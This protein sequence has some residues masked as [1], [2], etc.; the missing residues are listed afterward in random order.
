LMASFGPSIFSIVPRMRMVCGSCA[1]AIE[2]AKKKAK[3][4]AP[5]HPSCHKCHTILPHMYALQFT[6]TRLKH[7]VRCVVPAFAAIVMVPRQSDV[8]L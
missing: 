5:G 7:R 1:P 3:A 4:L 6:A 2:V 8:R